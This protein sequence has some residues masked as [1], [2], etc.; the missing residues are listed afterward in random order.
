MKSIS[1][2]CTVERLSLTRILV[3]PTL[4]FAHRWQH[5][6]ATHHCHTHL[7]NLN[8]DCHLDLSNIFF[9]YVHF[10]LSANPLIIKWAVHV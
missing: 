1:V 7:H 6:Y 5:L 9:N 2:R 4:I 10:T 3:R 8:T